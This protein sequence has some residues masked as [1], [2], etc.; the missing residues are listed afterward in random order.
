MDIERVYREYHDRLLNY[1]RYKV[2]N[3]EDAE[4]IL[5]EVFLKV[6][7]NSDRYEEEKGSVARWLYVIAGNTIIDHYRKHKPGEEIPEELP[8]D[9]DIESDTIGRLSLTGLRDALLTLSEEERI[10]IVL[11]YYDELSLK[12]IEQ[13]TGLSYGQVKIRHNGALNKLKKLLS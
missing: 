9:F 1:I 10:V 5:S 2:G 6:Q 4:D 13:K 8:S 3:E 12:E 7:K 11:H